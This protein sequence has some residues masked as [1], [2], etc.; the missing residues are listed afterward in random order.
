MNRAV[1]ARYHPGSTVKPAVILTGL[2]ESSATT[3]LPLITRHTFYHCSTDDFVT[4]SCRWHSHGSVKPFE[5]IKESCNVYCAFVAKRLNWL[6]PIWFENIGL[7]RLTSLHLPREDLATLDDTVTPSSGALRR[8]PDDEVRQLAIGQG[9]IAVSPLHVAN[10]MATLARRGVHVSPTLDL[11]N[12]HS[13]KLLRLQFSPQDMDL[14]IRA[15]EAV[16][17]ESGGTAHGVPELRNLGIRIAGKTGT[18][19]YEEDPKDWHCWFS[20]FAPADDPQVAFSV[21][22]EHGETGAKTAGPVA[23][24]LLRLCVEHGHIKTASSADLSLQSDGS[25]R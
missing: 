21:V 17:H 11:N 20:G 16:V 2:S 23:A 25:S 24:E 8:L 5:A 10:M 4:P 14:V 1:E 18:A 6:L 15:M 3:G 22:I 9:K 13:D 12:N 19:Q 7:T